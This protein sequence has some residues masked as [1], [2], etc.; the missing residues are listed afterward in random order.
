[1]LLVFLILIIES[2]G[3]PDHGRPDAPGRKVHTLNIEDTRVVVVASTTN[4]R[5]NDLN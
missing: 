5:P 4:P 3:L 1:M 2:Y